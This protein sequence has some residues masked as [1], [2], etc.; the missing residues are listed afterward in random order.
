MNTKPEIDTERTTQ[1][2]KTCDATEV[3]W[4]ACSD[5]AAERMK[6]ESQLAEEQRIQRLRE[7]EA[8]RERALMV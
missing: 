1:T 5:L 7:L 2:D 8:L 3:Q 6:T 4:T